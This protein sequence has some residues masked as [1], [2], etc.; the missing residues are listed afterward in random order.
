MLVEGRATA[1]SAPAPIL[2]GGADKPPIST[3]VRVIVSNLD[4]GIAE[5]DLVEIFGRV[6]DLKSVALETNEAG[7]S[8]GIAELTYRRREGAVAA[9]SE[10]DLRVID[11]RPVRV[12]IVEGDSAAV[13]AAAIAAALPVVHVQTTYSSAAAASSSFRGERG[14]GRGRGAGIADGGRGRGRGR[15][16]GGAA[17]GGGGGGRPARSDDADAE[18]EQ[19]LRK[20]DGVT[21]TEAEPAAASKPS[22]GRGGGRR[23]AASAEDTDDAFAAYMS[24]RKASSTTA[25][26]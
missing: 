6:G 4:F 21:A 10:Y 2:F 16:G 8:T 18:F 3:G 19:Y 20:R 11:G 1:G 13:P 24:Q 9:V 14:R 7:R 12:A 5:E 25:D 15:G 23:S 22:G 17:A 26:E